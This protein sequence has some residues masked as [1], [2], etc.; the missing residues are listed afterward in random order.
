MRTWL[1]D[2]WLRL[3]ASYWFIPSLMATAAVM[4]SVVLMRIDSI[5]GVD[6]ISKVGWLHPSEP[7]G[8][9]ALLSTVAGSMITVAGV[10]FSMTLLAVSHASAQIGPRLLSGFMRDRGNQFTLGTFIATFLYCLL[11][12]RTIRPGGEGETAVLFVPNIAVLVAVGMAILSVMVL[13]YFIHHVPQSINVSYVV[14]LAG[15]DV[16]RGLTRLFPGGVGEAADNNSLPADF[17]DNSVTI[18]LTDDFGYLRVLDAEAL[19]S[20]ACKHELVLKVLR[21]PGDFAVSGRPLIQAWPGNKINEGLI[22]EMGSAFTWGSQ[23]T[24]DQDVRMP[25]EQLMEVLAKAMSPGVNGQFTALLC[26]DQFER[27]LSCLAQTP[28]PTAFRRDKKG[29]LRLIARPLSQQ[30]I[31]DTVMRPLRQ[32]IHGDWLTTQQTIT[33]LERLIAKSS[34]DMSQ[35]LAYHAAALRDEIRSSDMLDEHQRTILDQV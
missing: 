3:K 18:Q 27:A 15:D 24:P 14:R 28:P 16:V 10:T 12:L 23:R 13:I 35:R 2:Q 26:I 25:I 19:M 8:A 1:A 7:D 4:A 20:L 9:R 22:A 32:F 34:G 6:W 5:V 21:Q 30:E 31:I 17:D 29:K 33:V 11:V